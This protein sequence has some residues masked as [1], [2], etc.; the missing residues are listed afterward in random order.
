MSR[1]RVA[2]FV[3]TG[4]PVARSVRSGT[5]NPRGCGSNVAAFVRTWSGFPPFSICVN[6]CS[7]V[8]MRSE[9]PSAMRA[10]MRFVPALTRR[11]TGTLLALLAA[12]SLRAA[13]APDWENEQVFQINREPARAS[14]VP[15]ATVEQALKGDAHQSPRYFS[16]NG[17]WRFHWVPRPEERPKDFYRPDFDDTAWTRFPVP[18]NWETHGY[19][20]PI[21]VSSGYPFKIDP[22]RVTGDPKPEYTAFKE[23]NPVGSYRREFDL[24]TDWSSRR[25]FLHFAGVQGAFYAW[26]NVERVGYSEGSMSPAEFEVTAYV[27]PGRNTLAVEVYRWSDGSYLEDQDMWRVSGIHRDVYLYATPAVRLRDFAVR[28]ELEASYRDATLRVEPKLSASPGATAEGWTIEAQLYNADGTAVFK[29]PLSQDAAVVL[30]PEYRADVLND[31]TPQRGPRKF[32]WL[33]GRVTAPA[34]WTAETPNLYRL[35]LALR[36]AQGNVAETVACDVGFREVVIRGGQLLVNGQP[37]RLRG[38]NRHEFDP[39]HGHAVSYE[40]MVQDVTLMKQANINAVRTSHYPNDPRWY[41]LCDRYGLYVLDEADLETHGTRGLLASDARWQAAFLDRAIRLAERDKNHPS[42]I[43]WSMGNESGYGPNFAAISA[44]LHE[45]DPTRP[46]HYEGAQ[47]SPT[48]PR[49]VDVISRFY[50][51][52]LHERYLNPATPQ[53]DEVSER[54][55]NARWERYLSIAQSEA[56]D[57]PVLTSEYAHAMG[58]ALGNLKEYWDEIYSHPRMLGGF[59]WEWADEGLYKQL[60][61]GTRFIAYGGDFGDKPNLKAFCLKGI[62]DS[63]RRPTP[64]YWEV[65]RVYQPIAVVAEALQASAAKLRVENRHHFNNLSQYEAR[66][67]IRADGLVL[68]AG[69]LAKLDLGPGNSATVEI[70]LVNLRPAPAGADRWLRVSFLQRDAQPGLPSRW[71]IATEQFALPGETA[72]PPP[73][74]TAGLPNLEVVEDSTN[75]RIA[76]GA[77]SVTF[78]KEKAT[79]SSLRYAQHEIIGRGSNE[80][81]GGPVL[82]AFRAP[83]DNDRGFGKW[84]ARDWNDAG[85]ATMARSVESITLAKVSAQLVRVTAVVRHVAKGGGLV[86]KAVY[87]VRGDG[88]VDI[89]NTFTPYGKL[90][91]LPRIGVMTVLSPELQVLRWYGEGPQESYADRKTSTEIGLWSS[92]VAEQ[93]FPYARPQETGNHEDVRWVA[94]S[95]AAGAGVLVVA[96]EKT[97]AFS[98]LPYSAMDLAAAAH[99]Y[100]LKPRREVFL[101]L[102]AR[103]CG[104]GNGSCGPGVLEKYAVPVMPYQLH[105]SFRPLANDNPQ[106]IAASARTTYEDGK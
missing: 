86:H 7:S 15:F 30:N 39:T 101:S 104:L 67:E 62:V 5:G 105:F 68:G 81:A 44:W 95:D 71:E 77:F 22:P 8:V 84:L 83:T 25:V 63:E 38:V 91:P 82:Q 20:T 70:P 93:P 69:E 85:L 41:E 79:L 80:R 92:T 35:V 12:G 27:R 3:R 74:S 18:A 48:D 19:G 51:R 90:P 103:Q 99:A 96:E 28:T 47:G 43:M 49:T 2:A 87:S 1:S 32:G 78:N 89:D 9:T 88:S 94:L 13:T 52:L 73:I 46:V 55:E 97:L 10:V 75:V 53:G 11:A 106:Q 33:E 23:R 50:P 66:W 60:P 21:Y 31:R 98:A 64:K 40:R 65:K 54:P 24:P 17:D 37:I 36:D 76:G 4:S 34:K 102:D 59:L 61:D 14:F 57:R 58:N 26:V 100:E 42:V 29:N 16:L 72:L 56:D 45:F 6:L